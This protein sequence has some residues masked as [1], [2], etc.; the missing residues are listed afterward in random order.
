M[1]KSK[2]DTVEVPVETVE[3]LIISLEWI[4][5]SLNF[6]KLN[7]QYP[8]NLML[9]IVADYFYHFRKLLTDSKRLNQNKTKKSKKN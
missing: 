1:S 9:R 2:F 5:T 4:I 8:C 7:D 3:N 6:W